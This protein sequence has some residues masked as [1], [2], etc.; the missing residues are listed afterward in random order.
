MMII[1][2]YFLVITLI[3][4]LSASNFTE[5]SGFKDENGNTHLFLRIYTQYSGDGFSNDIFHF[6]IFKNSYSLYI[7]D[8]YS[9]ANFPDPYNWPS[10]KSVDDFEF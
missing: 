7:E 2:T 4:L 5:L 1:R 3:S 9:P 8:Y 6:D 10:Y